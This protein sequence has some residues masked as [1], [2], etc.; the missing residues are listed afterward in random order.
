MEQ[1]VY[2]IAARNGVISTH[3][4]AAD[5]MRLL[6]TRLANYQ[7]LAES[8]IA[9][10]Q[11]YINSDLDEIMRSVEVQSS[12]CLE[13]ARAEEHIRAHAQ[14]AT[15]CGREPLEHLTATEAEQASDI[16]LRTAEL[17][18]GILELN[19]THAGIIRKL[20]HN[21]AV[22]QNLYSNALVY[23]DPRLSQSGPCRTLEE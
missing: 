5:L 22:L 7:A 9:S 23:A 18:V 4:D 17:K 20:A 12:H 16:L 13:I 15:A 10:R 21:N 14:T 6:Q 2:S 11:A 19:R 1:L 3:S 8:L